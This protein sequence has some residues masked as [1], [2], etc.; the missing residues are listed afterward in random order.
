MSGEIPVYC[1]SVVAIVWVLL[2]WRTLVARQQ[3]IDALR[4]RHSHVYERA[5]APLRSARLLDRIFATSEVVRAQWS[6]EAILLDR[7]ATMDADLQALQG[8]YRA[9]IACLI[10]WTAAFLG[11]M[12]WVAWAVW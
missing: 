4:T 6:H 2:Y 5:A 8:R 7:G 12:L 9:W 10:G 3:I 1:F 11:G